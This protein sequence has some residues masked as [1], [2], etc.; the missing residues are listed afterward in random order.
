M[1]RKAL[2]PYS[3]EPSIGPCPDESFL[4]PVCHLL[5]IHFNIISARVFHVVSFLQ[6]FLPKLC[7]RFNLCVCATCPTHPVVCNLIAWVIFS[8]G[9]EFWNAS[10]CW[11]VSSSAKF[12]K[13][14]PQNKVGCCVP[15][16]KNCFAVRQQSR[17]VH[18]TV[19]LSV[20]RQT[21][22]SIFCNANLKKPILLTEFS[23]IS[24]KFFE[25]PQNKSTIVFSL[26]EWFLF[27]CYSLSLMWWTDVSW[28]KANFVMETATLCI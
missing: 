19:Q 16:V 15:D 5:K 12:T 17:T 1:G 3:K 11:F 20:T 2:F 7:M 21:R 25:F 23:K 22:T 6:V 18:C 28:L 8:K 4:L 13:L 10:S 26:L 14:K 27:Y 9:Y 24:R